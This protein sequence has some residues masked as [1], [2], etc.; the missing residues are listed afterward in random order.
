MPIGFAGPFKTQMNA[1][2]T[3]VPLPAWDADVAA[4]ELL[5]VAIRVNGGG[6]TLSDPLDYTQLGLQA[7]AGSVTVLAKEADGTEGGTTETLTLTNASLQAVVTMRLT[8]VDLTDW[9]A[10]DVLGDFASASTSLVI[11]SITTDAP[12]ARVFWFSGSNV[13]D[14][15]TASQGTE[16]VDAT[17][18]TRNIYVA[19]LD[20]AT[21]GS[22]GSNTIT[23][24]SLA[25]NMA[26]LAL[27]FK[28]ATATGTTERLSPDAILEQS[29]GS[30]AAVIGDLQE[31]PDVDT[32][33]TDGLIPATP[34][35]P[36]TGLTNGPEYVDAPASATAWTGGTGATWGTYANVIDTSETTNSTVTLGSTNT[37]YQNFFSF[38]AGDWSDIPSNAIITG[39]AVTVRSSI[40]TAARVQHHIAL[41]TANGSL[42]AGASELN[43]ASNSVATTTLGASTN[44][45]KTVNAFGAFPTRAQLISGTFGVRFRQR[46]S[47]TS[48]I[49]I[50]SIKATVTY[51]IPGAVGSNTVVRTSF[52]TPTNTLEN[53]TGLQKFR[54]RVDRVGSGSPTARIELYESG[55]S[56]S[57]ASSDVAIT[58]STV[59][60]LAWNAFALTTPSGAN[61]EARV[62]GTGVEGGAVAI[63]SIE[64]NATVQTTSGTQYNQ[65]LTVT[66]VVTSTTTKQAGAIRTA[67][68]TGAA[69][70]LKQTG[71]KIQATATGAVSVIKQVGKLFSVTSGVGTTNVTKQTTARR[72]VTATGTSSVLQK[73]VSKVLNATASG[74][75]SA[76]R[77]TSKLFTSTVIGASSITKQIARPLT[78]ATGAATASIVTAKAFIL[79]VVATAT[80]TPSILKQTGKNILAN[81]TTIPS[82]SK[83]ITK[84]LSGVASGSASTTKST[85]K[86][87]TADAS[88]VVSIAKNV[89][90]LLQ[91]AVSGVA[92]IVADFIAG[93]N[94]IPQLLT[95][96]ASGTASVRKEI[97]AIRSATSTGTASLTKLATRLLQTVSSTTVTMQK[98]TSIARQV[99]SGA[100]VVV[101]KAI[102]ITRQADASGSATATSL[103]VRLLTLVANATGTASISKSI[104]KT[105]S[106]VATG[107]V[108][109]FNLVKSTFRPD[110]IIQ[111]EGDTK[112]LTDLQREP[113]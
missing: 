39:I 50:Y 5:V 30:V 63:Y 13:A 113:D 45:E 53:G 28:E 85:T 40:G 98:T 105:V 89:S 97:T 31:D 80:G 6:G 69:S 15:Y 106:V 108:D 8:G 94:I 44:T 99:S 29:G 103:I 109:I 84:L 12:N 70:I 27:A 56:K 52:G 46:R 61:V 26:G 14:N 48:T 87:I 82:I 19:Y 10:S 17:G 66:V 21:A 90:K 36:Q 43:L 72:T 1:N 20:K 51:D 110:A 34:T 58:S 65:G 16:Y 3:P 92:S 111:Q 24:A 42:L 62:V 96:T 2:A 101:S 18:S 47:N 60:E 102:S 57:V 67:I 68:G 75:T 91:S 59:I 11:P 7:S 79:S 88:G 55:S 4:G 54:A 112:T 38:A 23:A 37:D 74:A 100:S 86:D 76:V 93:T 64:W 83:A 71:K 77:Q 78:V 33:D 81:A 41:A 73:A 107:V 95:A 25:G 35:Q 9:I 104:A 22:V 32:T 49:T